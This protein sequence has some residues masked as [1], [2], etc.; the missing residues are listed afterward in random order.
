MSTVDLETVFE[1]FKNRFA[2][3]SDEAVIEAFNSDV[4]NPG[5]TGARGAFH[6]ALLQDFQ[7]RGWNC[8]AIYNSDNNTLNFTSRVKLN[9][10][11]RALEI[12]AE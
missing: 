2:A 5:W 10:E 1:E 11:K 3:M 12:V 7:R 6:K 4:G 8:D 9:P